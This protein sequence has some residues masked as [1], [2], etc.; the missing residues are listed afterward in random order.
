M[1]YSHW[2]SPSLPLLPSLAQLGMPSARARPRPSP[3]AVSRKVP[4]PLGRPGWGPNPIRGREGLAAPSRP[5][6][7]PWALGG[8]E[9]QAVQLPHHL[10]NTEAL[11][12][13]QRCSHCQQLRARPE[14]PGAS[15]GSTPSPRGLRASSP[16]HP[17]LSW[18]TV[19]GKT[20]WSP[21]C[22]AQEFL[23]PPSAAH[24]G[25]RKNH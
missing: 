18:P 7:H 3:A 14:Q 1:V 2:S 5:H 10:P 23:P 8:T 13:W 21:E 16:T 11:R 24:S 25:P 6:P 17:P 22:S 19:Q 9:R 4:P 20:A 15:E 12:P